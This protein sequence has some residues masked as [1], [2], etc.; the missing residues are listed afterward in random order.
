[1]MIRTLF[2]YFA[3]YA[4]MRVDVASCPGSPV[5]DKF[6]METTTKGYPS[7]RKTENIMFTMKFRVTV[8]AVIFLQFSSHSVMNALGL[9]LWIMRKR[10]RL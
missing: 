7:L 9:I 6:I 4:K 3:E 5:K 2:W 8:K 10:R 1:M